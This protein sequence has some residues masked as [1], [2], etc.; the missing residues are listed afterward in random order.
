MHKISVIESWKNSW[1]IFKKNWKV[2]IYTVAVTTLVGTILSSIFKVEDL[3]VGGF[4]T[5]QAMMVIALYYILKYLI[6]TLFNIGQTK[7]DIDAVG[8][9]KPRYSDLFNSQG[10]YL[11][12]LLVSILYGLAVLGGFILLIIPGIYVALRYCFAPILIIDKKMGV[13]EAFDK[14]KEMT[15]GKKWQMIGFFVVS[16]IFVLAGLIALGVGIVVTFIMYELAFVHLYRG[17][18]NESD[19][20]ERVEQ[21]GQMDFQDI[22]NETEGIEKTTQNVEENTQNS[23]NSEIPQN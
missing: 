8:G 22:K 10:V 13:G 19:A 5:S 9:T 16:I 6:Q 23:D 11:K 20:E 3:K 14:S 12:F 17:L 18:L 15:D 4:R 1:G 2:L 21:G 7:I